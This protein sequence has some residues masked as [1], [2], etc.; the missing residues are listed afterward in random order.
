MNRL[1]LGETREAASGF[2]RSIKW[3]IVVPSRIV[4]KVNARIAVAVVLALMR[5]VPG[6]PKT[7]GA[8]NLFWL[9]QL[10]GI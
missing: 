8:R 2:R 6:A 7:P 5:S 3:L 10:R 4:L 1:K 9:A